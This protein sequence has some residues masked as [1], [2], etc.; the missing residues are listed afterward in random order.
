MRSGRRRRARRRPPALGRVDRVGQGRPGHA[1][2][3]PLVR[4]QDGRPAAGVRADRVDRRPRHL[5]HAA[6]VQG[7]ERL[8]PGPAR[9]A[10]LPASSGRAD[11]H[12][13][14]APRHRLRRRHADDGRRRRLL[15]PPA[16]QPQGQPVLPARRRDRRRRAAGTRSSCARRRRTR[17][18]RRSSRTRRSASS[19]R[20]SRARTARTDAAERGQ[21][22]QGRALVQLARLARRRQRPVRAAAVQHDLADHPR[23]EPAL[24]GPRSR[25]SSASSSATWSRATQFINIQRGA[26]EVAIDLSAQQAQSLQG[27]PHGSR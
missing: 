14:S 16:D 3:R 15:V 1:R 22:G 10:R 9:R 8:A 20:S 2:R 24:L 12:V 5:R 23:A 11:V 21:D 17:R 18:S 7:R 19:T 25:R 6:H 26:H 4:D 13:Q 27:E